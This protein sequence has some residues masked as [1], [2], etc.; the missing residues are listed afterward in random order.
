MLVF[1][2]GHGLSSGRLQEMIV[3]PAKPPSYQTWDTLSA[4]ISRGLVLPENSPRNHRAEHGLP[5][6]GQIGLP[7][8]LVPNKNRL[9]EW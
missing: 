2:I 5:I 1:Q 6:S 4:P 9:G 7:T 3:R 8:A